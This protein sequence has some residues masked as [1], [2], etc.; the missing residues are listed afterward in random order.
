MRRTL[1]IA[2]LLV[3]AAAGSI[4]WFAG[5]DPPAHDLVPRGNMD[6]RQ[7]ALAFNNNERI[8]VVLVQEGDHAGR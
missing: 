7:V 1:L 2:V 5:R 8:D 3:L 4:W 6:L